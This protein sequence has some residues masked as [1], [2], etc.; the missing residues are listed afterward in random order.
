MQF[1]DSDDWVISSA[2][3]MTGEAYIAQSADE[4]IFLKRNSSPFLAVLSAE[5]F[6]PKLL[7]TKRLANGD[8]LTAQ[9]WLNGRELNSEDM[10]SKQVAKLLKKIHS[11]EPLVF[12]LSR[13]GKEPKTPSGILKELEIN[14]CKRPEQS[15]VQEALSFLRLTADHADFPDKMVCHADINHNNWIIDHADHLYLVDWDQAVIAD[16]ALDLALM[17]YWYVDEKDWERWLAYYGWPLTDYLRLRM[18]WYMLSQTLTLMFWHQDHGQI[19]E[20]HQFEKDLMS[21]NQYSIDRFSN[22]LL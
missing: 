16:P 19:K 21:L 10:T 3:G 2:G 22:D 7:W 17:L 11:S 20:A 18:H 8:V 15:P 12:M 13:L 6:V 4:K 9:Q 5:G 14:H 1:F